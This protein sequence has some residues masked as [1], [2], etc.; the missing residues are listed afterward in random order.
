MQSH[1]RRTVSPYNYASSATFRPAVDITCGV[2]V[3]DC[4]IGP[5]TTRLSHGLYYGL[6]PASFI[7]CLQSVQNAAARL[8]FEIRQSEHITDA[9]IQPTLAARSFKLA[10]MT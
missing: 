6:L 3:A 2:P 1:V 7:H 9:L 4:R 10:V 5:F 8:L